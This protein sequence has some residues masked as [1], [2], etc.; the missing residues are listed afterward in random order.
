[1]S[2][3]DIR[4]YLEAKALLSALEDK[5]EKYRKLPKDVFKSGHRIDR[6]GTV[7]TKKHEDPFDEFESFDDE[8]YA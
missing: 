4:K 1:M 6:E 7:L 8:E 2:D 3:S 5:V